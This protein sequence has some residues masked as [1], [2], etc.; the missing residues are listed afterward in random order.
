MAEKLW[1][2]PDLAT[3]LETSVSNT[4]YLIELGRIPGVVRLGPRAIR[5]DPN[6]VKEWAAKGG[7]VG[8]SA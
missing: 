5:I 4:Y 1:K 6:A 7:V 2:V 8:V 3:Y